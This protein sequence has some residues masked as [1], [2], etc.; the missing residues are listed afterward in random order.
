MT[1]V[2]ITGASKGIGKAMALYCAQKGMNLLL[3][4]RSANLLEKLAAALQ[5]DYKVQ[6]KTLA[7]DLVNAEAPRRIFDFIK[8]E[9][10]NV[11]MLVNNAGIGGY[12]KFYALGLQKQL[13]MMQ[14]N[15]NAC[16][17]LAH[18]FIN[19]S[20]ANQKRYLLNV[21][22]TAAFQ[23]IPSMTVYAATKAFMLSFSRGLR[24]ELRRKNVHVTALCPGGTETDFIAEAD[25][26]K[27]AQKNAGF[28]MSAEEVAKAGIEGVLKNKSVVIPGFANKMGALASKFMPHDMVVPATGKI[29]KQ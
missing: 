13:D 18:L 4:A 26:G 5:A 29:F 28:M 25:L 1:Y 23:A 27:V 15:M 14:L 19:E 3:V 12:G 11:N 9:K 21:V 6:V 24:V 7:A 22:S 2:L 10:L 20:D 17:Q 16:V 8:A